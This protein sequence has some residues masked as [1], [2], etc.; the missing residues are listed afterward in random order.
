MTI[1]TKF[2]VGDEVFFLYESKIK[3]SKIIKITAETSP[4]YP[5][6]LIVYYFEGTQSFNEIYKYEEEIAPTITE[7]IN[8][9]TPK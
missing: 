7:L 9:L 4:N 3:K 6:A 5:T 2:N 8:Q 1:T